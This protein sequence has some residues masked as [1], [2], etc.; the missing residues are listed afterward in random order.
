MKH[1][2]LKMKHRNVGPRKGC[3]AIKVGT[4]RPPRKVRR[5]KP[6]EPYVPLYYRVTLEDL[7]K[8]PE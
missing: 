1:P 3:G 7:L 5:E 6:I 4:I 2:I 8:E